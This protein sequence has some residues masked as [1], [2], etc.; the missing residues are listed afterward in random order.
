M[1][2]KD[3]VTEQFAN[4]DDL[5]VL[6]FFDPEERYRDQVEAWDDDSGIRCVIASEARF[7]LKRRLE[8][9]LDGQDVLLYLPEARPSNWTDEPLLDL[10][11]ANRELRIDPVANFMETYHLPSEQRDV[12]QRY[13]R[14]ELE[15]E[16]Q[17]RFLSAILQ[18]GRFTSHDLKLGLAAFHAK[19][20]FEDVGFRSVPREQQVLA[21]ILIGATNPEDFEEYRQICEELGLSD[22]LGR[23]FSQQFELDSTAF[24]Y[25]TV[26]TAAQTMKYN[27]LLR[28]VDP[29]RSDDNYRKLRI[30]SS[31]VLNQLGSLKNAWSEHKA[32]RR[33]PEEVLDVVA[34][35]IDE[36]HLLEVY[37]P[38]TTFGYLTPTL[39]RRRVT[40]ALEGLEQAP[41]KTKSTV[42]ALRG[43]DTPVGRT[44]EV[45]G[46]MASF[47]QLLKGHS[48]MDFGTVDAFIDTYSQELYRADTHYRKAVAAYRTLQ[49]AG[50]AIPELEEAVDRFLHHYHDR[51]VHP[52]NT[53]WQEKLEATLDGMDR[54]S[55]PRQ[56]Q[57]Y[58]TYLAD[59]DQ[60]TAVVVSDGLRFEVAR[61]LSDRMLQ[62]DSRKETS[63]EP[64]LAALPSVTSVGMAH[65]LPHDDIQLDGDTP[66][67]EGRRTEGT[68]NREQILQSVRE[69]ACART[70]DDLTELSQREG[71]DLFKDH[72]LVYIYHNH[73]DAVGDQRKTEA[74]T[75]PAIEETVRD[76][77]RLVRTLNNW[78]VYRVLVVA[79]H[80]FLYMDDD[81]PAS[82][83]E[84]FPDVDGQVLRCNRSI[85]AQRCTGD[86]GYRFPLRSVSDI[87]AELE[88]CVPRAVNRYRLQGA[89]KRYA[90][91]GASL[92]E[93]LVPALVVRKKREDTAEKVGVRLLS[94]D[95]VIR[96]GALNVQ[97]LQTDAVSS[98]RQAR[99]LHVGL[100]NDDE[101][102]ISDEEIV[103]LD[104][105]AGDATERTQK[106]ML[107]LGA[108]ANPLNFCHLKAYDAED[109]NKLN[110]IIK[111]RYSIQRLI[112]QDF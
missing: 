23:R 62:T 93:M 1:T 104:S 86:A 17:Q 66:S 21:A 80:G 10:W 5:R 45:I 109:R 14:G 44:A 43:T 101:E 34:S 33:G 15:Y 39:R 96:S 60:K 98:T 65:L 91:G 54:L 111:Q 19:K 40:Q 87:D 95:R 89:G 4:H 106:V 7:S 12:L 78:N 35:G 73:I 90:H 48:S 31:L 72:P 64:M 18:P 26:E 92:Q 63:L 3:R 20:T 67:I 69:T 88:V 38:D 61:E 70:Y 105:T 37:G 51:F 13:F 49:E 75:I 29:V 94:K 24:T 47:Y 83:Q 77:Q 110:P 68:A 107:T 79:D 84:P 74:E 46:H 16:E 50:E 103:T 108:K 57:F 71:R 41:S 42:E 58:D 112:E 6:F 102:L 28:P 25:E 55:V 9:D 36:R 8:R 76:L 59:E 56:G 81:P 85:V 32:L 97:I 27:L 52:L 11:V 82:M 22:F 30:Q 100:Y 99:T 53:A 2:L